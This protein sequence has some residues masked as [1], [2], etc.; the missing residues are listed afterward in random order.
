MAGDHLS[1]S[2]GCCLSRRTHAIVRRN[3]SSNLVWGGA[4]P[5][6]PPTQFGLRLSALGRGSSPVRCQDDLDRSLSGRDELLMEA[7]VGSVGDA[8]R[9]QGLGYLELLLMLVAACHRA[10]KNQS[11]NRIL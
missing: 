7:W 5:S 11:A 9:G 2:G 8:R 4:P 1:V 6:R 10:G 3:L